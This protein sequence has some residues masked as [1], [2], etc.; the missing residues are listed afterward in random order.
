M[1]NKKDSLGDR[2]KS[3]YENVTRYY[4]PRRTYTII[5]LDGKAFHTFTKNAI[6]PFDDDFMHLMKNTTT[7]LMKE[8]QNC[9]L[10]YTQSDEISLL[11]DDFADVDTQQWLGGNLQKICSVSASIATAHFN[12]E[13]AKEN[14]FDSV[15][16]FDSRVFT[17]PDK[18]EVINYLVW[19]TKDA[20]RNSISSTAQS[21][22]SHKELHKKN[23]HEQ[24]K[25]IKE[26]GVDWYEFDHVKK[27]GLLV[28]RHGWFYN[29]P[30]NNLFE[31]YN[32]II[33]EIDAERE[34]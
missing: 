34:N 29:V 4:L 18:T 28:D 16:Y 7:I 23:V 31:F 26:K 14:Y 20:I 21:L 3:N 30:T 32:E 2:M 25:M 5:R 12:S 19:R 10:A 17:I 9:K 22:Y 15:G 24:L 27:S 8:I 1:R 13:R 6:K 33:E 11:L